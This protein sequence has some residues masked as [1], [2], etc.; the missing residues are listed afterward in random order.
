MKPIKR[1]NSLKQSVVESLRHSI[2]TGEV[3]LGQ[4]LSERVLAEQLNVSKTPV[5]EAL[6]QL[7]N[8]GLVRAVPQ[9]GVYVFT[10]SQD[11][12]IQMCE[13]RQTLEVAA[14]RMAI[15]RQPQE[16]QRQLESIVQKM[17]AARQASDR[18]Q[19][20]AL[21]T[22]FHRSFFLCC[23]NEMMLQTYEMNVGKISAL[24]THLSVRPHHTDLS[25]DE[26]LSI[27]EAVRERNSALAVSILDTHI[28][29]TKATYS[30]DVMTLTAPGGGMPFSE[31]QQ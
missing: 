2:V 25:F 31:H 23:K 15:E 22:L 29:R 11:E 3:Q 30:E 28:G 19:Y 4:I 1:P 17:Q 12:V 16:I 21:D 18:K 8:E 6:A 13:L 20:L 5:R 7:Q 9:R 26:H 10:P 27:L 14:L 24:R